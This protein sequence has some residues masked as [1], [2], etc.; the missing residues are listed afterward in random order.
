[1]IKQNTT[2]INKVKNKIFCYNSQGNE[3]DRREVEFLRNIHFSV[4]YTPWNFQNIL[5]FFIF[6]KLNFKLILFLICLY[7]VGSE[8]NKLPR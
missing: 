5:D 3:N 7:Y 8:I 2:N 1:L 4:H 6:V